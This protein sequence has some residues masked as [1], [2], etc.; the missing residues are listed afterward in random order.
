MRRSGDERVAFPTSGGEAGARVR[1]ILRWV[2][3]PVHPDFHR[4]AILPRADRVGNDLA[5]HGVD[6]AR[7]VDAE[8]ASVNKIVIRPSDALP[9]NHRELRL[10]VTEDAHSTLIV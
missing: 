5:F 3:P 6:F 7:D 9:L 4:R 10:V 8:P 1:R 2:R